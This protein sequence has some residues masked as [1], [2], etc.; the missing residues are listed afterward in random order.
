MPL[1]YCYNCGHGTEY[2]LNKPKVCLKCNQS[3]YQPTIASKPLQS[4]ISNPV[5]IVDPITDLEPEDIPVIDP[6]SFASADIVRPC[7]SLKLS[8]PVTVEKNEPKLK[9]TTR[10]T[11]GSK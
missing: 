6:T 9:R 11:K 3:F 10:K 4:K 1:F 2:T 5:V 7:T 8:K